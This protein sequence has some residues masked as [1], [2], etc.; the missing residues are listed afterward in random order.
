MCRNNQLWVV[1]RIHISKAITLSKSYK[2]VKKE[3]NIKF[4]WMKK[5]EYLKRCYGQNISCIS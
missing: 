1:A 4:A 2:N 3:R 5:N